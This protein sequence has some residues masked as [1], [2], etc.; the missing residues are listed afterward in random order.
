MRQGVL[1]IVF[2]LAACVVAP[3][4][5]PLTNLGI[6]NDTTETLTLVVNGVRLADIAPGEVQASVATTG[7]PPLPWTITAHTRSG[8]ALGTMLIGPY[9]AND[10]ASAFFTWV[11]GTI[12]IWTGA[13]A[14]PSPLDLPAEASP[15]P[16]RPCDP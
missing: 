7:L 12:T 9:Q 3:T 10:S 2:M 14:P 13:S 5:Q 6:R 11:C 15:P 16:L 8:L 4:S 1:G